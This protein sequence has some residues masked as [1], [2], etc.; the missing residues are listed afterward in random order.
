MFS[1]EIS[2]LLDQTTTCAVSDVLVK[3]GHRLYMSSRIKALNEHRAAGRALTIERRDLALTSTKNPL[4]GR[5]LIE[6]IETAEPGTVFVLTS[7]AETEVALWGGLISATAV[8]R[9][10]GGVV[11]DGPVRDPKEIFE[12]GLACFATGAIP[13]GPAGIQNLASFNEPIF[14]GGVLVQPGDFVFGDSNG[15]VVIPAGMEVE[16]LEEAVKVEKGDQEAMKRIRAGA[17]LIETMKALGR[18]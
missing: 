10:A 13:A 11:C 2:E 6:A 18:L 17:G 1:K 16:I 14:C 15:V 4:P 8:Q 12:V 5:L 9:R 3:R 7:V